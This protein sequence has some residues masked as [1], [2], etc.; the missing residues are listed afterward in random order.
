MPASVSCLVNCP[1]TIHGKVYAIPL[2]STTEGIIYNQ[3]LFEKYHLSEPKTY[4]DFLN[5]CAALKSS[6]VAPLAVGGSNFHGMDCW[7][8]YFFQTDVIS[9]TPDWQSL[10]NQRKVSFRDSAPVR[11]LKDYRS[12]MTGPYVLEDSADM[13]DN[14]MVSQLIDGR[15]AMMYAD[16]SLLLQIID[17]YPQA[18]EPGKNTLGE[19]IPNSRVKCRVGWFF[20]PDTG[21]KPGRCEPPWCAMGDFSEL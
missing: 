16:P 15:F 8:D 3:V 9:G 19:S 18:A 20:L 14:Q 10:R 7:L 12:L 13:N 2:Y 6:G 21:R 5:L 1:T 4:G 17:A 11:M